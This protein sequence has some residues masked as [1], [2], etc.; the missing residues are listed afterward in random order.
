MSRPTLRK[1]AFFT[2]TV[3]ACVSGARWCASKYRIPDRFARWRFQRVALARYNGDR[4]PRW[5][6]AQ[7]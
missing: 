3:A 2:A 4:A 5:G 6:G 7:R 1:F